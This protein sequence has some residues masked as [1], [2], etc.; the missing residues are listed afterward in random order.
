MISRRNLIKSLGLSALSLPAFVS[1]GFNQSG[2]SIENKGMLPSPEDPSYWKKI[3][4]QFMLA[5]DKV[6]FNTGN[7]MVCYR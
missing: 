5:P 1:T 7:T 3:R 2:S 4:D 6:F